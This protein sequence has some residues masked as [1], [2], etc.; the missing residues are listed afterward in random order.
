MALQPHQVIA[1]A[2]VFLVAGSITTICNKWLDMI[3]APDSSGTVSKFEHPFFQTF[4]M[5]VGETI[6]LAAFHGLLLRKK[7]RQEPIEDGVD[8]ALPKLPT[9]LYLLP[10]TCDFTATALAMAGLSLTDASVYQMLMGSTL[11]FTALLSVALLKRRFFRFEILGI[12][13]VVAGLTVVGTISNGSSESSRNPFLGNILVIASQAVQSL[14]YVIEE[15]MMAVYHIP[16]LQLVGMEGIFG[17]GISAMALAL[18]QAWREKPDD[19]IIALQQ[20]SN[21]DRCLVASALILLAIPVLNGAAVTI[22]KNLS[23]TTRM[24]LS[25]LRNIGVW[26]FLISYGSYFNESFKWLQLVGFTLLV[27]GTAVYKKL[28][29]IPLAFFGEDCQHAAVVAVVSTEDE[30]LAGRE[31]HLDAPD[32]SS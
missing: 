32:K 12:V 29:T 15:K 28:I 21:C 13:L 10:A 1:V 7:W 8:R 9:L 25:T 14:Q 6:C 27:A 19:V 11:L 22:T 3:E 31:I 26:V 2:C 30:P 24:V 4:M 23:A 5:F 20:L 18:F 16:P 17:L